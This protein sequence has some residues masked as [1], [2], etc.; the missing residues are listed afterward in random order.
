MRRGNVDLSLSTRFRRDYMA[1]LAQ[2]RTTA[3]G[4]R[5]AG[6]GQQLSE[7]DAVNRRL[8]ALLRRDRARE[9]VRV[10]RVYPHV[11]R[12]LRDGEALF[13]PTWTLTENDR[14]GLGSINSG[15]KEWFKGYVANYQQDLERHSGRQVPPDGLDRT[16]YDL[17]AKARTVV[18]GASSAG[19]LVAVY[20]VS[21][22]AGLRTKA[23]AGAK[24]SPTNLRSRS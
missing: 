15:Y 11:Y 24:L 16:L 21:A 3:A 10:G 7:G 14:Y 6:Q 22:A 5:A 1:S 23:V 8:R 18:A 17:D 20:C 4:Q 2:D 13:T 19:S 9:N 12:L